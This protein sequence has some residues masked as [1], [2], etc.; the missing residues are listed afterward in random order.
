MYLTLK[1]YLALD[2]YE[3]SVYGYL[4]YKK[5][6]TLVL[7]PLSKSE[8]AND[9]NISRPKL[10]EVIDRLVKLGHIFLI[11]NKRRK[12]IIELRDPMAKRLELWD[13]QV[14]DTF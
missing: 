2:H 7:P 6:N 10:D 4:G 5:L 9:L 8:V 11:S 14:A 13:E 1:E 3:R 12:L